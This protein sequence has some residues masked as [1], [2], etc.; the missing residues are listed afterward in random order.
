MSLKA[1]NKYFNATFLVN[2][3][4]YCNK[5]QSVYNVIIHRDLQF[6]FAGIHS[7]VFIYL[8]LFF[9]FCMI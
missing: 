1:I 5:K 6:L 9:L 4:L 8:K 2:I 3:E 7:L